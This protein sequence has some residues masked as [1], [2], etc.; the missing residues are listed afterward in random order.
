[1]AY[2]TLHLMNQTIHVIIGLSKFLIFF[3]TMLQLLNNTI[4]FINWME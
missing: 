3:V 4:W 1:M 2:A